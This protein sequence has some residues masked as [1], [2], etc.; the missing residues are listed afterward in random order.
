MEGKRIKTTVNNWQPSQL[1]CEQ[2][3]F[4]VADVGIPTVLIQDNTYKNRTG[5]MVGIWATHLACNAIQGR[6]MQNITCIHTQ[7]TVQYPRIAASSPLTYHMACPRPSF[8]YCQPITDSYLF[9]NSKAIII[10]G[11]KSEGDPQRVETV[12]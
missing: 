11:L 8:L 3:Q 1:G 2:T 10:I 7:R 6:V 12:R 9:R 4:I 5:A